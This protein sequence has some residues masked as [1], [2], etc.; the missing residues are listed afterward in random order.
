VLAFPASGETSKGASSSAISLED[1]IKNYS[2]V[3]PGKPATITI[4]VVVQLRDPIR[5]YE[6]VGG[7]VVALVH[8][9]QADIEEDNYDE[10][11]K[12]KVTSSHIGGM[13]AKSGRKRNVWDSERQRLTAMHWLVEYGLGKAGKKGKHVLSKGQDLLWSLSSRIMADM[14]LKHMRNPDVKFTK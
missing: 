14:W 4:A 11:K 12:F 10:E 2:L 5:R 9:T 1:W 7:P 3:S 6:A 13:K 8:A